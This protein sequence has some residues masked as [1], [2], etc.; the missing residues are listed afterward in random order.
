[1]TISAHQR[2]PARASQSAGFVG[3]DTSDLRYLSRALREASPAAW[4]ALCRDLRVM[5]QVVADDARKRASYSTRIPGSIHVAG[6]LSTLKVVAGGDA[7]PDG[8]PLENK[9]RTGKFRHPVNAW[10]YPGQRSRWKWGNQQA[11]PFLAPALE[12]HREEI[13]E[14]LAQAVTDEIGKVV[15]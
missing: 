6:R 5:A 8:A 7:A 1:V 4:R 9:G 14:H 13:V 11:R 2:R 10:A 3:V 15:L 12:A